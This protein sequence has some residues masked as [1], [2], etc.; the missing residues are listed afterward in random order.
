[1]YVK[2]II[3]YSFHDRS[4]SLWPSILVRTKTRRLFWVI[5]NRIWWPRDDK[6]KQEKNAVELCDAKRR[7]QKNLI[8]NR[9]IGALR[10]IIK[11][12]VKTPSSFLTGPINDH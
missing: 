9:A 11:C 3:V 6:D 12:Q 1:M 10:S 8:A 5:M 7:K 4:Q 2:L